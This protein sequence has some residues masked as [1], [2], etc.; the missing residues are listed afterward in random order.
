MKKACVTVILASVLLIPLSQFAHAQGP[1]SAPSPTGRNP[2]LVWTPQQQ[3]VWNRMRAEN[4]PWMQVLLNTADATGT[5]NQ[6]YADLGQWATLA[7]QITGE[8]TYAD[9][10]W[11]QIEPYMVAVLDPEYRWDGNFVREFFVEYVVMYDWL[12]PA[13]TPEQR[14]T[15]I[16]GLNRH[17]E[18]SL[19]INVQLYDGGFRTSD[20][21]Q[22]WGQYLGMALVDLATGPE[23]PKAGTWLTQISAPP[24]GYVTPVGGLDATAADF[25]TVRNALRYRLEYSAAGGEW[26]ESSEYNLGTPSFVLIGIQGIQ[27]A[28]GGNHFPEAAPLIRQLALEMLYLM[29]PDLAQAHQWGDEEHPRDLRLFYRVQLLGM[30]QGLTQNDPEVGPYLNQLIDDL[31]AKYGATGY[32]SAEPWWR[33]FYFYNPFAA[34][35]EWHGVLPKGHFAQAMGVLHFH[36][37]WG[38]TDSHLIFHTPQHTAEDHDPQFAADFQL[39]RHGEWVL[40]HP[41]GYGA[42]A[43]SGAS[44]NGM[45]IAGFSSMNEM[46]GSV[47][48]EVGTQG[49]YAYL[50]GMTGGWYAAPDTWNPPPTFL[51][52]WTRSMFYLPSADKRSDTIVVF[53]RV[54]AEN[55]KN[56]DLSGYYD[57]ELGLILNAPDLKQWFIHSPVAPTITSTG[58]A[59]TT[60]GGQQVRVSTLLP[61]NQKRTV[62]DEKVIWAQ[63]EDF[64]PFELKYHTVIAPQVEQQWDTFLN[65]VQVFD[66]GA[67]LQNTLLQSAGGEAQGV[68]IRRGGLADAVVLFGA[69]PEARPLTAGYTVNWTGGAAQTEVYALDLDPTKSWTVRAD[70]GAPT[71]LAVSAQGVGHVPVNGAGA[72]NVQLSVTGEVPNLPPTVALTAPT[73]GMT[74]TAPADIPISATASDPDGSIAK[75]EF[76]QGATKLGEALAAPYQLTWTTVPAGSY[77]LTARATDNR[78][79]MATSAVVTITVNPP[80]TTTALLTVARAGTGSGTVTS[81]DGGITCGSTC[82]HTYNLNDVVTLT[83][84][85]AADSTFAGWSGAGCGDTVTM[86][87]DRTCT[88]TF[89]RVATGTATLTI[90][91]AGT[92]SGTVTSADGGIACGPTCA[93]TYPLNTTVTLT[94]TPGA[95]STFGGWSGTGC[96]PTVAVSGDRACAATFLLESSGSGRTYHVGPGQPYA[97]IGDVP[98]GN[99]APGDVVRIHWR[100][101]PY[102]EKL[103]ISARGTAA[104]AIRFVGVPGPNGELPQI[105]GQQARTSAQ[106]ADFS[107]PYAQVLG[108][109][110]VGIASSQPWEYVPGY[111]TFEGLAGC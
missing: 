60:P 1:P 43:D 97:N 5:S 20:S 25:S 2:R 92:G 90:A 99:L 88:A 87:S 53:D 55:P 71:A 19:G 86:S 17:C 104:A 61:V 110:V 23:N 64:E 8:K 58:L 66:A 73:D 62:N 35:A 80:T 29:T 48:Q 39:Y 16:N 24:G 28:T 98:F 111:L 51:H 75:V 15:Y 94:A 27:T 7:F 93:H 11:A 108:T 6:A 26:Y 74:F 3:V 12:Y 63:V 57:R 41:I 68:R 101:Q 82:A 107:V 22:T 70:G 78:G 59:W 103:L 102:K 89:T 72:H 106:F 37:G 65:I 109:I 9:K 81:A 30:L 77:A 44:V 96:G 45:E 47:S 46:R 40:T 83:A 85:P 14:Q 32:G 4:H 84:T 67:V 38:V 50:A 52:E 13:L 31:V 105:D 95:G 54:N 33:I 69:K 18:W 36:D 56:L 76:F 21:D 49:E 10:A 100:P 91:R 34:K 42:T 79:A